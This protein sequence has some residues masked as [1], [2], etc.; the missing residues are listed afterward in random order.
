MSAF[1]ATVG[2]RSDWFDIVRADFMRNAFVVGALVAVAAGIVGYFVVVRRDTFAA[3][4]LAHVGFPGATAALLV[5]VPLLLGTSVFCVLGALTIGVLGR[6]VGRREIA[7]GTVLA[8]AT[9]VG[10]LC[11]A[12]ASGSTA[13][14]TNVLFGNLLAVSNG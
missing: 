10:V 14:L 6:D 9:A 11:N 3:H 1:T 7:T 4:A 12:L 8:G 5:G 2:W 13:T